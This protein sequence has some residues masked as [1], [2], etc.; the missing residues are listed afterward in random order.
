MYDDLAPVALAFADRLSDAVDTADRAAFERTV[1]R[2]TERAA[3][4][5]VEF[6]KGKATG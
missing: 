6:A 1:D 2:L 5:A 3:K 4:L